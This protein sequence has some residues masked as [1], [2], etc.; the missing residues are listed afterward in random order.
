MRTHAEQ[1]LKDFQDGELCTCGAYPSWNCPLH[2][3]DDELCAEFG[4]KLP[5]L[6]VV[7]YDCSLPDDD[8]IPF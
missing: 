7:G 8:D 3:E 1:W 4:E 2:G 6:M 5:L